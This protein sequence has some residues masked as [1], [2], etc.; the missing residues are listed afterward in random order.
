MEPNRNGHYNNN[1]QWRIEN[2]FNVC[3]FVSF[4]FLKWLCAYS[5]SLTFHFTT[6]ASN[7]FVC[8][9]HVTYDSEYWNLLSS[10]HLPLNSYTKGCVTFYF[11]RIQTFKCKNS[12]SFPFTN[13]FHRIFSLGK[14]LENSLKWIWFYSER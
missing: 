7:T 14:S 10:W 1:G 2:A 12:N 6:N 5:F 4:S 8:T 13:F 9:I 11:L 3:D